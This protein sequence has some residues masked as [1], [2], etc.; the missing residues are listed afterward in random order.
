MFGHYEFLDL[1]I[2]IL[3]GHHDFIGISIDIYSTRNQ[4][5]LS[6]F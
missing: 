6:F 4:V 3:G 5:K 1:L 2:C